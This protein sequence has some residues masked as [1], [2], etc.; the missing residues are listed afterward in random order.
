MSTHPRDHYDDESCGY[1]ELRPWPKWPPFNYAHEES[2]RVTAIIDFPKADDSLPPWLLPR[3]DL[4]PLL[5]KQHDR[6]MF[7]TLDGEAK[8]VPRSVVEQKDRNTNPNNPV[9]WS[10]RDKLIAASQKYRG[11]GF[12]LGSVDNGPTFAGIDLDKCRNPK[13]GT[14]QEW[15]WKVIRA[16]NSYT[17][18]SPSGTGVKISITGALRDEDKAQG[19]V[20][21]LEIYDRKRYFTVTGHH[22]SGTPTTVE[23]RETELRDLY[24]RQRSTDLVELTKLFGLFKQNRGEWVDILC[25]WADDHGTRQ[26][27]G[28]LAPSR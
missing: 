21:Q 13:T 5:L 17:E 6:W 20:Y 23:P 14:I 28:L 11:P 7:W 15:A 12:A 2:P 10:S 25:P 26:Q 24:A 1:S 16:V 9:K 3:Y 4:T 18:I 27:N 8:K 22:L 19:K